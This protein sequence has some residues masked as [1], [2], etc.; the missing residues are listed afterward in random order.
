MS[1]DF[2]YPSTLGQL[3]LNG[4]T[5]MRN[6]IAKGVIIDM[7]IL[8]KKKEDDFIACFAG[9]HL[10]EYFYPQLPIEYGN[11]KNAYTVGCL[12]NARLGEWEYAYRLYERMKNPKADWGIDKNISQILESLP[13]EKF[14]GELTEQ[15]LDTF[16]IHMTE[17]A[18][19]LI[20]KG[21]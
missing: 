6:M 8:F 5:S 18:N 21:I 9:C 10:L 11:R 17:C 19:I 2:I 4:I 15:A 1:D 20:E 3:L 14:K 12:E 7:N 13:R 16:I